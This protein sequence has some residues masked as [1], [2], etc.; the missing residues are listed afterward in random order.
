MKKF[1]PNDVGVANGN[2]FGFPITE[3][4]ADLVIIP[5]PWDIT[6]SYRKGTARGPYRVL[7]A[8]T[9]LDFYHPNFE[10][11]AST[12]VC[13]TPISQ[14]M[15]SV[16]HDL[17]NGAL[18]YLS[19]LEQGNTVKENTK[20][21][22][23][24]EAANEAHENIRKAVYDR[25]VSFQEAGKIVGVIG[26]EHSVPLGLIQALATQYKSFG[27]LQ[28][29]AHADLRE[30]YEG[31]EQSH[32]SIMHNVL[33]Q[34]PQ[35][36]KL[37]QVGVRDLSG[38]EVNRIKQ[39]DR[40]VTFY[41]WQLKDQQFGGRTWQKQVEEIVSELP[42]AVY[43][44]FDIDGLVPSLCPNTGTPVP[45][46]MEYEQARFLLQQLIVQEK[47]IIGFDLCEVGDDDW[48]AMV[49]AR[50]LWELVVATEMSRRH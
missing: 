13:M 44:S 8:S 7:E 45:G 19:Y 2:I 12:R 43:I 41:D 25:A 50:I 24:L 28:I 14:D 47:K 46:G 32:A 35:V 36:K 17:T 6:A 48:D 21:S 15:L 16:N 27:I 1:D 9:Q 29:D 5:V 40:I 34:V 39:S 30:S 31:F 42:D 38:Q 26:G 4:E 33:D 20:E 37:I 10:E 18:D 22:L 23:F 11:A 3:Q 49:G